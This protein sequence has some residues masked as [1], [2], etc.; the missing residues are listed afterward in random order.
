MPCYVDGK[1]YKI[2]CNKT[3]LEY[4]GSTCDTLNR[5]LHNHVVKWGAWKAGKT[6]RCG[7]FK[8]LEGGDYK[9]ELLENFPCNSKEELNK[10][11]RYWYDLATTPL[12]NLFLPYRFYEDIQAQRKRTDEKRKNN[13]QRIASKKENNRKRY[14]YK[15]QLTYYNLH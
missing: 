11:E 6:N 3:G 10:R 5:R 9:I 12:C 1:I 7:S 15:K 4:V 8:I 2:T 13:P 14:L